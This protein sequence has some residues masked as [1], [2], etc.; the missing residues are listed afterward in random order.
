MDKKQKGKTFK[1]TTVYRILAAHVLWYLFYVS[2][3]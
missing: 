1:K 3:L 2:Q